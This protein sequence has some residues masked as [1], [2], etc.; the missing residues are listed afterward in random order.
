MSVVRHTRRIPD[1]V[2]TMPTG[3]RG[4]VVTKN[5]SLKF[6]MNDRRFRVARAYWSGSVWDGTTCSGV[7]QEH[8][9]D[10]IDLLSDSPRNRKRGGKTEAKPRFH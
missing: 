9:I 4:I 6:G 3:S 10:L 8:G 7:L 5:W 1:R 2:G